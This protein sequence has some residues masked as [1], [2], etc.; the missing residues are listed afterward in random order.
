MSSM[1]IAFPIAHALVLLGLLAATA[2]VVW[3]RNLWSAVIAFGSFNLLLALEFYLLQA[4]DVAIA[5]AGIG[6]GLTTAI[7]VVAIR[8]TSGKKVLLKEDGSARPEV[9]EEDV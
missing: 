5:A 9:E 3:L 1:S 7:F 4:P 8:A 2:M 6:A